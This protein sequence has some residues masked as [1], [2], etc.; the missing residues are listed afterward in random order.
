MNAGPADASASSPQVRE[1]PASQTSAAPLPQ[2]KTTRAVT[3]RVVFIC[4]AL[5]L[6]FGYTIPVVDYKFSNTFLGAT[7]LAPG[8]IGVLLALVVVVN[9]LLQVL[10]GP[11]FRFARDEVLVVYLSC[12]FSCLIQESVETT[13]SRRSSSARSTTRRERTAGWSS[14]P[15]CHRG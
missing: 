7:H 9:P 14:S 15:S 10:A 3:P 2:T 5:S 1:V 12:L 6:F 13:T 8:A 4:L 11:R